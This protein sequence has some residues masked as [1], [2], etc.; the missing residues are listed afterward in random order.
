MGYLTELEPATVRTTSFEFW[1][2]VPHLSVMSIFTHSLKS[3]ESPMSAS[4]R[5][6][7]EVSHDLASTSPTGEDVRRYKEFLREHHPLLLEAIVRIADDLVSEGVDL[8]DVVGRT[9][10]SV[11]GPTYAEGLPE[12]DHESE[13]TI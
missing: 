2:S 5:D 12:Y 8:R 3:L 6:E 13:A 9:E 10:M 7:I 11:G 4:D 1:A